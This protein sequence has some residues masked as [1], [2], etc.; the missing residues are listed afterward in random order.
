MQDN[1]PDLQQ[2]L[3]E[4]R[5]FQQR[6]DSLLLASAN[7]DGMPEAS[8]AP[9]L[10]CDDHYLILVS[11]LAEHTRNLQQNPQL[12]AL[13]IEDES[14]T[15]QLFARRRA[16]LRLSVEEI[17]AN[18]ERYESS[19]DQLQQKFGNMVGMLRSLPDFHLLKL[20][21]TEAAYVRGFGQAFR[22][23]GKGLARVEWQNADTLKASTRSGE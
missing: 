22:L 2:V 17:N 23:T 12:S 1:T 5:A 21:P 16:R 3:E 19:L 14:Q 20:T 6:F 18:D 15:R 7:L 9:A 8:Y 13:L 10:W 4:F 11:E